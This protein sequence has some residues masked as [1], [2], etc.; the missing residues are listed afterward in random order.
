MSQQDKLKQR[1]MTAQP[2]ISYQYNIQ[3]LGAID[4]FNEF[5]LVQ[6]AT[7]VSSR[8]RGEDQREKWCASLDCAE[9]HLLLS[10]LVSSFQI[11][12][13]LDQLSIS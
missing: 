1:K 8:K 10:R 4:W 2:K 11:A 9:S 3:I 5:A 6:P 12:I 7:A 13:L